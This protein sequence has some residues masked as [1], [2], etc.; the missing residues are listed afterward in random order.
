MK[1]FRLFFIS[2]LLLCCI[3]SY[4]QVDSTSANEQEETEK[5]KQ[6]HAEI[7]VKENGNLIVTETI[8]VYAAGIQIDH[9]IFRE[10]PLTNSSTKVPFNNFYTILKVTRNG[11]LELY[12][13]KS[14][15]QNFKI[16]IGSKNALLPPGTY[17]YK[18]TYEVEAQ[19]HSYADFDEVYWNV[20]GNYWVFDIDNVTARV[21][22]PK[23]ATA[24]QTHCYTGILGSKANDCN[25]KIIG[26]SI[27]FTS[28][29]LK[30]EEGL[31]VA[32]GF[33][34]GIVHQ[35]FFLPHF[36]M[37]EFLSFEKIG[38][39]LLA[40]TICFGFYFYSWKKYGK[41]P[42]PS[43]EIN[44]LTDV[45]KL[46]SPASLQYI[47]ER[48]CYTKTLL[49]TIISL[50]V[51]GAIEITG[52]GKQ[53]WADG[54]EYFLKKGTNTN[55]ITMEE[56]VV[57]ESLFKENDTFAINTKTYKIFNDAETELEKSLQSQYNTDDYFRI[58]TKQILIG[59]ALT[60]STILAYCYAA[61]GMI[62]WEGIF[63]FIFLIFSIWLIKVIIKSF[64]KAE[65]GIALP[66]L[67]ILIF[68]L[69][70]TYTL[71]IANTADKSYSALN[72]LTLFIIIS[73]FTI[74]LTLITA[75]TK[76]G[77][78]TKS[79]TQKFKQ[80]LLNYPVEENADT[81]RVYEENL[82]YAFALDIDKKWNL[83]F[84]DA[85]KNLNYT[86]NWITTSDG[87]VGFSYQTLV[88][89]NRSYTSSSS[90]SSGSSGG[91]SSGGGGG[92]GGG[93]GW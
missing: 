79:Q 74:Y 78:K 1:Q 63:G 61:K 54:F 49:T 39:A 93:G 33:P 88:S 58:N 32:V 17:T 35:P 20:T 68:P 10:L 40:L 5:I 28:K 90:S 4:S 3:K 11:G 50:S 2:F 53:N 22:L 57:L 77:I 25:A 65:F 84:E 19:I 37:E 31:T 91:G 13:T 24:L 76:L 75:Y 14:D 47:K 83:K 72:A 51:K 56:K 6:F 62:F 23:G 34:K 7:L 42:L 92:G 43:N 81:I 64:I 66:S 73:G 15:L 80:H 59:F 26:N 29:N 69:L 55:H 82:P 9:G 45:K 12:H 38:L 71:L 46:Y 67:C 60:I 48:Y 8:K 44:E 52:N 21:I 41:D 70:I 89:F 85:L 30:S 36:K 18:L 87:S 16:Y 86:S 27:Y